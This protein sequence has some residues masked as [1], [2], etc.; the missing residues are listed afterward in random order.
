MIRTIV[1]NVVGLR[2]RYVGFGIVMAFLV[3]AGS[4]GL[5]ISGNAPAVHQRQLDDAVAGRTVIVR[6]APGGPVLDDAALDRLARLPGADKV[7]PTYALG[8]DLTLG[9]RANPLIVAVLP[10]RSTFS[11]PLVAGNAQLG[12]RDA[13]VPA[14]IDGRPMA[15]LLGKEITV[16]RNVALRPGQ[17]VSRPETL[18]VAG[19]IEP[20]WQVEARNPVYIP[21]AL[22]RQWL[23]DATGLGL[24]S[25]PA[26]G[27]SSVSVLLAAGTDPDTALA[28][29]QDLGFQVSTAAQIGGE[30]PESLQSFVALSN[31]IRYAGIALGLVITLVFV[32]TMLLSRLPEVGLLKSFG[33]TAPRILAV[34]GGELVLVSVVAA[35]LGVVGGAAAAYTVVESVG[36][37]SLPPGSA[38]T[39]AVPSP[40]LA[41][42]VV[43]SA[44]VAVAVAA[45]IP[46]AGAARRP[47]MAA[48]RARR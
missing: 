27:F 43:V 47:A 34:L 37:G 8:G 38:L 9:D 2:G 5:I 36:A 26:D 17:T 45:V 15:E 10:L 3:A 35:V 46:L 22:A 42:A 31:A 28:A 19:L 30:V 44:L 12:A 11:P 23:G 14:T 40:G 39:V 21:P 32:R 29:A 1:R 18:R 24:G 25:V 33:Y 7:E 4:A 48:L 20:T 13:L 41:L 6:A 16:L